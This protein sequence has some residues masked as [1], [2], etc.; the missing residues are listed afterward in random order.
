MGRKPKPLPFKKDMRVTYLSNVYGRIAI[1]EAVVSMVTTKDG[2]PVVYTRSPDSWGGYYKRSFS[3]VAGMFQENPYPIWQLRPLNGDNMKNLK[4]RAEKATNLHGQ[5]KS[6]YEDIQR[7]V[8]YEAQTWE[9]QEIERRAKLLEH[10]QSFINR[11]IA[12]MGFKRPK[13]I[14]VKVNGEISKVRRVC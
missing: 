11:V 13:E 7:Q 5:Y 2:E 1:Q 12:R 8:H 10:G 3:P 9:H 14:K 6:K 4:K